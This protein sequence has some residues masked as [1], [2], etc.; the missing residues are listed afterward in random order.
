M[1]CNNLYSDFLYNMISAVT[2]HNFWPK[3]KMQLQK[4][5]W[6]NC[7]TH[8]TTKIEFEWALCKKK[9]KVATSSNT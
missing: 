7:D 6:P 4:R 9:M 1:I 5:L 3:M 2:N 8:F